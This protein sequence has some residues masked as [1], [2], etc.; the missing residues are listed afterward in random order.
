ME[1]RRKAWK[2]VRFPCVGMVGAAGDGLPRAA[3]PTRGMP[4]SNARSC[5]RRETTRFAPR[6]HGRN[7]YHFRARKVLPRRCN[8]PEGVFREVFRVPGNRRLPAATPAKVKVTTLRIPEGSKALSPIKNPR[9]SKRTMRTSARA[10]LAAVSLPC[11]SL[12][13]TRPEKK[14]ATKLMAELR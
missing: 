11:L 12:R 8:E 14:A 7:E 9:E 2:V 1:S 4:P 6:M 13:N 3:A 10:R 5:G